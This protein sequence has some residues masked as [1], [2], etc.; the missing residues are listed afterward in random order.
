MWE[1]AHSQKL[2][3]KFRELLDPMKLIKGLQS[4]R[5]ERLA[6]SIKHRPPHILVDT[7]ETCANIT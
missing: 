7:T 2:A 5:S 4:R 1:Y 6:S 3:D